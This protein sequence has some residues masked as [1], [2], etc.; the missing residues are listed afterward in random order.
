[1]MK[2]GRGPS[3][4][5]FGGLNREGTEEVAMDVSGAKG[6]PVQRLLGVGAGRRTVDFQDMPLANLGGT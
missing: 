5:L 4:G 1:M 3:E 2:G 6:R